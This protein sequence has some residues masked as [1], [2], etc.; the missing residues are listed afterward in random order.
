MTGI[1]RY[2]MQ[3]PRQA[4]LL[5]VLFAAIPLLY[6]VSAAIVSLVMLRQGLEKGINVLLPALLPGVAWYAMQQE[7]TVFVVILGS[8]LMAAVLRASVSLPKAMTMAVV[9]GFAIALLL[10]DL[11]P[12]WFEILQKGADEYQK[13]ITETMPEMAEALRPWIL[14]MLLGGIA[15]MLQLFAIGAVLLA[16]HWQSKLYNPGGF[17]KEFHELRLPMWYVAA[18]VLILF[19]GGSDPQWVMAVP[20]VLVPLFVMGVSF[21]H[22][23]IAAKQLSSQWLMAFYISLLFFL[24]Y[25]YALLILIAL[26]DSVIDIRKRLKDT[27]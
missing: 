27:A 7:I 17:N 13:A 25:M 19:V 24:P 10:P 11:S 9:P 5:A 8:A 4:V 12:M 21:V 20:V 1:A 22:G 3:G 2:A 16:R 23:V 14:P 18:A 15:A 6:W 26:M